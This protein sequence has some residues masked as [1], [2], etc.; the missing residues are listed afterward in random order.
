M[1]CSLPGSS[2]H[3]IFQA[4]VL[5]CH[6]FLQ[7]IF[8]TQ[9]LNLGLL[10]CRQILY[11]LSQQGSLEKHWQMYTVDIVGRVKDRETLESLLS[12]EVFLEVLLIYF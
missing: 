6:V 4:G 9:G 2:V 11:C 3:G 10:H 12:L 1:D 8:L 7:G 5:E